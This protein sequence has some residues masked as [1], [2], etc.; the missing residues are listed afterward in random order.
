M[1]HRY[2]DPPP[3]PFGG[4]PTKTF[5]LAWVLGVIG[6]GL[7]TAT[8]A[9]GQDAADCVLPVPTVVAQVNSHLPIDK[10]VTLTTEQTVRAVAWY[11]SMPPES[12]DNFDLAVVIRHTN[13]TYGLLLGLNGKV[14]HI[15]PIPNQFV[16]DLMRVLAGEGEG[17]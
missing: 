1:P 16:P 13:R 10:I 4:F 5:A 7:V 12:H 9:R 6:L 2:K 11:N 15:A 14:C 17:I 8:V 3:W